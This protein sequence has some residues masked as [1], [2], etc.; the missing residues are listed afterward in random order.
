VELAPDLK[1]ARVAL[2]RR[3]GDSGRARE[4]VAALEAAV[5]DD[6]R[7]QSPRLALAQL[8]AELG[9]VAAAETT[10]AAV[11]AIQP[12]NPQAHMD[13]GA[14]AVRR[15]AAATAR[16]RFQTVLELRAA[17]DFSKGLAHFNLGNL[18]LEGGDAAA[19]EEHYAEAVALAPRLA[20]AHFNLASARAERG[21]H[22]A[23]AEGFARAA[24]L[25]PTDLG[26]RQAW[27]ASL[28]AA[29]RHGEAVEV[30]EQGMMANSGPE[31]L[32]LG[33]LLS[34]VLSTAPEADTRDGARAL[35][36]ANRLLRDQPSVAHAE[37]V[38]MARAALGEFDQAAQW[39]AGILSQ[40]QTA[41]APAALVARLEA[42]LERYR[43]GELAGA[44][45]VGR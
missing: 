32:E 4:A 29:G 34:Q 44:P 41:G 25:A 5:D 3:L 45:W 11:L 16:E 17:P 31:G 27:A 14:L 33:L 30:L 20:D 28:L 39:Q 1:E 42:N 40:A 10:L 36:I 7:D 9:D 8:Q 23:A 35:E 22:A 19:A 43:A 13:L 21:D 6:P 12:A 26:V 2:A 15:G 37:A 38:A 24:E 18:A